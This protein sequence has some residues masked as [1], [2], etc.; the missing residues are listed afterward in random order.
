M[1]FF[2]LYHVCIYYEMVEVSG[3]EPESF[4]YYILTFLQQYLI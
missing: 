2:D 3:F 4:K 1:L